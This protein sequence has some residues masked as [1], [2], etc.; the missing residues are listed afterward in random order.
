MRPP[1]SLLISRMNNPRDL[2]QSSYVLPSRSFII[3]ST[4]IWILSKS[5]LSFFNCGTQNRTH[6]VLGGESAL[7]QSKGGQSIPLTSW[8]CC[9]WFIPGMIDLFLAARTH[10]WLQKLVSWADDP[11]LHSFCIEPWSEQWFELNRNVNTIMTYI[12]NGK[13]SAVSL[14][15]GVTPWYQLGYFGFA[16]VIENRIWL[17]LYSFG[18]QNL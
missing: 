11:K 16:H 18:F 2:K 13:Y 7:A 10:Y 4:L 5:F 9:A 3:F 15:C 17:F 12:V 14:W 6:T 8:Q 1:F